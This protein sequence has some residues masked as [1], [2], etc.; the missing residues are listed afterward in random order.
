MDKDID[1]FYELIAPELF[2]KGWSDA[3]FV[4]WC[5]TGDNT[6]L[7]NLLYILE[8]HEMFELCALVMGV[9]NKRI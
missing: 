8:Q 6:E 9:L 7:I 4:E 3:E 1:R 2:F 5:G